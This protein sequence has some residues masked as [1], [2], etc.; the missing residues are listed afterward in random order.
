MHGPLNGIKVIEFAGIGPAPFCGMML[1]DAGA[2]VV[3]VDKKGAH[4]LGRFDV[5]GRGRRS[6][7]LDLKNEAAQSVAIDLIER[8]DVLIEG[9][10]PGVMERLNLGPDICLARN[11]R[12]IYGR[13]TG[14]G[15]TG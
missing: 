7:A 14:W 2:D 5:L 4:G 3:R 13:M 8:A 11:P 1:A 9:F 6:I 10:R 12:L 15:Q